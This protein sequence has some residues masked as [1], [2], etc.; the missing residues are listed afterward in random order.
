MSRLSLISFALAICSFAT[1]I[2]AS[3]QAAESTTEN[4]FFKDTDMSAYA[5][6]EM[7]FSQCD[8]TDFLL[9]RLLP[10]KL[11]YAAMAEKCFVSETAVK[12]R[13]RKMKTICGVE[14]RDEL[15]ALLLSVRDSAV[16]L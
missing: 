14:S 11:S 3:V 15:L 12:Y 10:E 7:M 5:R 9:L 8:H 1:I 6:L 16:E 13:I 2:E 4:P